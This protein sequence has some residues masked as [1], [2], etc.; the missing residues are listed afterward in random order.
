MVVRRREVVAA[1]LPMQEHWLPMSNLDLLLPP[2]DV[3]VFF[4]YNNIKNTNYKGGLSDDDELDMVNL[5]SIVKKGLAQVLVTYYALAGEVVENNLG[6][7]ELLCNNRGV[8]F[9]EAYADLELQDLDLYNPD[10]SI[11]GKFVPIKRQGVLSVQVT[12]LKCGGLVIGCTFDHRVADAHS[13][14]MFFLA[15]AEITRSKSILISDHIPCYRR[16]LLNPRRPSQYHP[17]IN[18]MYVL[19]SSLPPSPKD[20]QFHTP[21]AGNGNSGHLLSRIYHIG[22]EQIERLQSMASSNGTKRSKLETFSALLWKLLAKG[23]KDDDKRCKMGIVVN[24]R[25][26]FTQE[27][28]SGSGSGSE[29][30][31]KNT[32]LLENYFGNVLSI[33][34]SDA[35]VGELKGMTLAKIAKIVHACVEGATNEEHFRGLIDWVENHR[36][37]PAMSKVYSLKPGD[38]DEVAV[39]VSSGQ[40]FPVGRLDFGWG[41]PEFG[42]YHFPWG[43]QTGYVMPMPSA[44]K[45][46]DWVVYMHLHKRHLDLVEK[47]APNVFTP[48]RFY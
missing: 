21:I 11:D 9:V 37:E 4:C 8:N 22:A 25:K 19:I 13:I 33:P 16:S 38:I 30:D 14:N 34:Y 26:C 24:G 12:E 46:G 39:V 15:W 36:P 3:G 5:I 29:S 31:G 41:R 17:S 42:S 40:R 10:A 27:P 20:Q 35:S 1:V 18:N 43:G 6:E 47:E 23:G 32:L 44:S 45:D 28:R 48:F 7:P 2:L